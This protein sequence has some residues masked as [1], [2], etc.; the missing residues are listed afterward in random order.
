MNRRVPD[1]RAARRAHKPIPPGNGGQFPVLPV[2]LS[3]AKPAGAA[4]PRGVCHVPEHLCN[5]DL[6]GPRVPALPGAHTGTDAGGVMGEGSFGGA[7]LQKPQE[8]QSQQALL[9]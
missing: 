3:R 2:S 4:E 7:I 6:P 8:L 9:F 1:A 5:I